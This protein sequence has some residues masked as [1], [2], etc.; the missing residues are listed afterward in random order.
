MEP[1]GEPA[2]RRSSRISNAMPVYS[3]QSRP[4]VK[5]KREDSSSERVGD[6]VK[7]KVVLP[8]NPK[9]QAKEDALKIRIDMVRPILPSFFTT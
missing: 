7:A 8:A 3:P 6:K 4:Y 5:R 1:L 2:P 9:K